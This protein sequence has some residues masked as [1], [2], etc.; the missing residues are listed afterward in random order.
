MELATELVNVLVE[1]II[2]LYFLNSAFG[3][4]K[5]LTRIMVAVYAG[6]TLVLG[7][8]TILSVHLVIREI[9]ALLSIMVLSLLLYKSKLLSAIYATLAFNV[10]VFFADILCIVV[11]NWFGITTEAMELGGSARVACIVVAKI[12]VLIEIQIATRFLPR[13]DS[14][15]PRWTLF[16]IIG[17]ALS[18]CV[19]ALMLHAS[20]ESN[21]DET[22][23]LLLS[24]SLIYLNLVICFYIETIRASFD[25]IR[26]KELA[27]QQL[28]LQIEQYEREISSRESTRALWHDIKRYMYAM[29]DLL[30]AG[31]TAEAT[32]CLAQ[33]ATAI[34]EIHQTVDVGNIVVDG[35]LERALTRIRNTEISLKFDVWISEELPIAAVDLNIIMGNTVDNAID[36]CQTIDGP[37]TVQLTLRQNQHT[38]LY[39]VQNPIGHPKLP[40]P[41]KIHGYGLRNV[42]DCVAKYCGEMETSELN[43]IYLVSIEIPI[44]K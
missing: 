14:Q 5:R 20:I 42:R 31:K 29:E 21:L 33:T 44:G 35:I 6:Y 1:T 43:G 34:S 41:G 15:V 4:A 40:K 9:Y 13:S 38:L 27:E 26:K 22:I 24:I 18:I 16:L 23:V 37:N 39:E 25:N 10:M 8:L 2:V 30:A 32:Q 36:A 28:Q 12:I 19:A 7:I 11:L 3:S 17:Q